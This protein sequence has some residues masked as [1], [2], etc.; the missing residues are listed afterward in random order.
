[1]SQSIVISSTAPAG[2]IEVVELQTLEL[3][4]L[5]DV[6]GGFSWADIGR[7]TLS[8]LLTG[9]GQGLQNGG[10]LKGLMTGGIM[11]F[12]QALVGQINQANIPDPGTGTGTPTTPGEP[13]VLAPTSAASAAPAA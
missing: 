10:W 8:G 13:K 6:N 7:G 11:G 5:A 3:A 2:P 12:A 1:M 9:A 4:L